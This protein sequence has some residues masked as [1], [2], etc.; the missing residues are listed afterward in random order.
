MLL[1]QAIAKV[2]PLRSQ[3]FCLSDL[4]SNL[5]ASY[6][7]DSRILLVVVGEGVGRLSGF[8]S[9]KYLKPLYTVTAILHCYTLR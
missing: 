7:R 8:F 6:K 4:E 5:T 3:S 1:Q 2:K 9:P